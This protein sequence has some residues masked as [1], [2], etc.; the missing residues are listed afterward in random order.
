MATKRNKKSDTL[1]FTTNTNN[2][3][4]IPASLWRGNGDLLF[5]KPDKDALH[6]Q[7]RKRRCKAWQSLDPPRY[8]GERD[9]K[10]RGFQ[11]KLDS[12]NLQI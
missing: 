7:M 9:H 1:C 3:D 6:T 12:A 10:G 8:C 2:V 5:G 4:K 11:H